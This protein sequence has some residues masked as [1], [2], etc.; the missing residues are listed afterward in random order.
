MAGKRRDE[1]VGAIACLL[2]GLAALGTGATEVTPERLR[3]TAAKPHNWLTY[4]GNQRGW[5]YSGLDQINTANVAELSV[6]W[7]FVPGPEEDF[8]ATPIVVDGVMYL[9]SPQH[10]VFALDARNGRILWRYDHAFPDEMPVSAWGPMRH[11]GVGVA[12]DLVILPTNDGQVVA[13][14]AATGEKRWAVQ[15]ADYR[16]GQGFNFPPLIVGDKAIVGSYTMEFATRGFLAALDVGT[17]EE[18]WR[19]WTVPGP[20]E[21]GNE[22]WAGD[23][24]KGGCGPVILPPTYDAELDLIYS[25][26]GNPCPMWNGDARKGDNLYT[27]SMLALNPHD[28]ELV[29]YE[30]LIPHDVW[31]LDTFGEVVL[32][33]TEVRGRQA[34]LA[35][36]AGKSGFFYAM[37]RVE[38]EFLYAKP[39]VERITWTLGLDERGK[40]IPGA[41]PGETSATLCPGALSGGK[42]WNQTAYSP[43]LDYLFIPAGEVC[44]EVK[45]VEVPPDQPPDALLP[46]GEVQGASSAGGSLTA[47]DMKTGEPVW[48]FESPF[49]MRSSVL[50]T[51]GDLLFTGD[52]ESRVLALDARSGELVWQ[53]AAGSMPQNS[54]TY[55]VDGRQY[56]AVGVGW[57][58]VLANFMPG[59]APALKSVPRGSLLLVFAL[60]PRARQADAG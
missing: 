33:D 22:T 24:W 30:Q 23:S 7:T 38:G 40:P 53:F 51:A 37:D 43:A 1:I 47:F 48:R 27:D 5:R 31:D 32:I 35:V 26:T 60:P 41:V 16:V 20:G 3:D 10:T 29:W 55:A 6:A 45:K 57:G 12:R 28:G 36:Q 42:S 18:L 13:L 59:Y 15:V 9:V 39:F 19:F 34:K 50:A 46:G 25:G 58:H 49:P 14:D 11:R 54:I 52:L 17:G 2:A 4:Y 21:A 8:Q 56:V 44:D